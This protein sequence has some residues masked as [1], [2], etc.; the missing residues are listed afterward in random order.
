M[1][2]I[3]VIA[4]VV[5]IVLYS[6]GIFRKPAA[7]QCCGA[8]L[9]GPDQ[10]VWGAEGSKFILCKNCASRVHPQAKEYAKENWT[11]QDYADY[12]AW[13]EATKEDR[14]QFKPTR[15]YGFSEKV[16]IDIEKGLFSIGSNAKSGLVL[17]FADLTSYHFIFKPV[18]RD[19]SKLKPHFKGQEV[20][21]VTMRNPN[22]HLEG[23]V[24]YGAYYAA[25]IVGG[26]KMKYDLSDNFE[27]IRKAFSNWVLMENMKRK[28]C[29][30]ELF[31]SEKAGVSLAMELLGYNSIEELSL[32]NLDD[33]KDLAISSLETDDPAKNAE[34]EKGIKNAYELL[35]RL[36]LEIEKRNWTLI[37]LEA[38]PDEEQPE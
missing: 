34:I 16:F 14:S 5:L 25:E 24:N 4:I 22:L 17:R 33:M 18:K 28:K 20:V 35:K 3:I 1:F 8:Q 32:E 19:E 30:E 12:L 10:V 36:L 26:G 6:M 9:K 38:R 29:R 21:S 2:W 37:T 13:D 7:C 31:D 11:Y 15:E 23:I 27:E